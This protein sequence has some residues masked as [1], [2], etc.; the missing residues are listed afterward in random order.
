MR[1]N[2]PGDPQSGDPQPWA[3]G[4]SNVAVVQ[5]LPGIGDMI[6][7]LPH[8]KA[9]AAHLHEPVTVVAKPRS[10]ADQILADE[11]CVRDVMWVDVNPSGR[12]G[13][14]DGAVGFLRLVAALRARRFSS[15][16]LLHHSHTLAAATMAAGIADRRGYGWGAQRWFL[17]RGPYLPAAVARLHQHTR[18][19]RFLAAAGIPL[20]SAEPVMTVSSAAVAAVE[21]RL[22]GARAFVAIGIGSSEQSRQWGAPRLAALTDALLRAGWPSVVLVGGPDDAALA[23]EIQRRIGP[24]GSRAI[25][26]LG[27]H[28][29]DTAAL[30]SLSSFY[31]GNNTGVMNM[32]AAVGIRTYALFGT[33]PPFDH[34]SQILTILSPPGGPDDGMVRV[35]LD[36]V[37]DAIETDRGSLAP[38]ALTAA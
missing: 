19:T 1:R 21:R 15:V 36:A 2:T 7:H 26:A 37:L 8:I 4:M 5:P 14:H 13:R 34:A 35:T 10:L 28:L 16:I 32:A 23:A 27:W 12:R 30:L 38:P 29:R 31:V 11:G 18:A 20:A 33:T 24:D 17:S 9:I 22:A 6:W 3:A 25:A